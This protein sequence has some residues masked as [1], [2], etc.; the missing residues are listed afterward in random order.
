MSAYNF[1]EAVVHLGEGGVATLPLPLSPFW[2]AAEQ[3]KWLSPIYHNEYEEP[4]PNDV[5]RVKA[6]LLGRSVFYDMTAEIT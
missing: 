3:A 5:L 6:T 4:L 2:L 1:T